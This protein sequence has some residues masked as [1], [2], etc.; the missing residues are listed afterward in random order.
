MPSS[1]HNR[2][3][4][5][6]RL[7]ADSRFL[8]SQQAFYSLNIDWGDTFETLRKKLLSL[9]PDEIDTLEANPYGVLQWDCR[10]AKVVRE[11]EELCRLPV[12]PVV[13]NWLVSPHGIAARKRTQLQAFINVL[14]P[15]ESVVDW[16]AGK[17]HLGRA[18]ADNWSSTVLALEKDPHLVEYGLREAKTLDVSYRTVDLQKDVPIVPPQ[19]MICALHACG[20]LSDIALDTALEHHSSL[21]LSPCCYHKREHGVWYPK[22]TALPK[23]AQLKK[24]E[25]M[26][27]SAWISTSRRKRILLRKKALRYRLGLASFLEE[28]GIENTRFPSVPRSVFDRSFVEFCMYM[29]EKHA[30]MS[31]KKPEARWEWVGAERARKVRALGVPRL[32]FRRAIE[33]LIVLDASQ[34]LIE[35][36]REVELGVFC[37]FHVTPRNVMIRTVL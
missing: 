5:L 30:V 19:S 37:P 14:S 23:E 17:A 27:P 12:F 15:C 16:C 3:C 7:L 4:S 26:M 9:S 21:A 29:Q 28:N 32:L 6:W 31:P 34:Y 10:L 22:S 2:L 33:L 25:L 36:G 8:W 1:Y 18:L 11:M 20:S 35:A 13:G 24:H